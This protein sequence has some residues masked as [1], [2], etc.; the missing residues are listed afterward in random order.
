MERQIRWKSRDSCEFVKS[1][2]MS[3]ANIFGS[4]TIDTLHRNQNFTTS[5]SFCI[6]RFP[7]SFGL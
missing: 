5:K 3:A 1:R 7:T 6:K 4:E 2:Q